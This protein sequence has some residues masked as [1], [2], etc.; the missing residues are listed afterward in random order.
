MKLLWIKVQDTRIAP[1][2]AIYEDS[3][4]DKFTGLPKRQRAEQVQIALPLSDRG[5]TGTIRTK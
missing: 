2:G 5:V 1:R 4:L 3:R